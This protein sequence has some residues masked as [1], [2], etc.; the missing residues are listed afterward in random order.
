MS[1]K[2]IKTALFGTLILVSLIVLLIGCE[3]AGADG[4]REQQHLR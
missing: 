2:Y 1:N 4:W 3:S